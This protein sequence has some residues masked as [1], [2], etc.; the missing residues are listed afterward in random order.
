MILKTVTG[1]ALRLIRRKDAPERLLIVEPTCQ[2]DIKRTL[3]R[4]RP[5]ARTPRHRG[6]FPDDLSFPSVRMVNA[7]FPPLQPY[8][9]RLVDADKPAVPTTMA[10]EN[11]RARLIAR[12]FCKSSANFQPIK[13]KAI[14]CG[15]SR[16]A[17]SDSARASR[18]KMEIQVARCAFC[19]ASH[20]G[21][22]WCWCSCR[23]T[24]RPTRTSCR[25]SALPTRCRPR[26]RRSPT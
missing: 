10:T 2:S 19:S 14:T 23:G 8:G 12:I 17:R 15:L 24:R 13:L 18:G 6:H 4:S 25:R 20:S 7:K 11:L 5:R 16:V 9:F 26:P 21:S 1:L 22:G 3:R